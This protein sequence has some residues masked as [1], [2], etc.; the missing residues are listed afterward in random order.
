MKPFESKEKTPSAFVTGEQKTLSKA[1]GE[2]DIQNNLEANREASRKVIEAA[3]KSGK[4][5]W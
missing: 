4:S 5:L 2:Q 1:K 3:Q